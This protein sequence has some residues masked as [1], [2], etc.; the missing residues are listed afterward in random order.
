MRSNTSRI[1]ELRGVRSQETLDRACGTESVVHSVTSGPC[2][3]VLVQSG[4]H[5][6]LFPL[7]LSYIRYDEWN[8]YCTLVGK[9]SQTAL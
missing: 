5:Q 4:F 3:Q 9:F 6:F 7:G 1:L 2:A 8:G